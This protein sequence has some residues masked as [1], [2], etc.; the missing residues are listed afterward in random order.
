VRRG[1]DEAVE[2]A[3]LDGDGKPRLRWHDLRHCYASLLIGSGLDPVYVSRRLGHASA[4]TTLDVY[5]H[6][7]RDESK[8]EQVAGALEAVMSGNPAENGGGERRRTDPDPR[9]G[10]VAIH[11]VSAAGGE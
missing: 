9:S 6:L 5:S 3:G 7:W 11:P 1:L 8:D 10:N 2:R 4:S